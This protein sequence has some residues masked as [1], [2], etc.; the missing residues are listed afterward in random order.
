DLLV[1]GA[2]RVDA[3]AFDATDYASHETFVTQTFD[4]YGDFDVVLIAFGVLGEQ[5]EA[6]RVARVAREII[7]ANFVGAV[8]VGVPI[9]QRLR[10]QGHGSLVVLSSVAGE[11]ARRSNFVYGASKAG[12]DAFFQGFGDALA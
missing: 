10:D 4:R 9:V 5:D 6:E 3:I 8:S 7:E 1:R 2:E 11:R 12:F